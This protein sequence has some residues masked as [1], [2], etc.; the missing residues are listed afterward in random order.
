MTILYE[1]YKDANTITEYYGLVVNDVARINYN[2]YGQF[3]DVYSKEGFI[4][5]IHLKLLKRL[6]IYEDGE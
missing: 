4:C 6:E 1:T 3:F 2:P 5:T